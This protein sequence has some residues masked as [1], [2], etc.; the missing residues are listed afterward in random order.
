M[1]A[2]TTIEQTLK[3]FDAIALQDMADVSL[4]N[5]T[6]TKFVTTPHA[7]EKFLRLAET[8]CLALE[9]NDRRISNYYTLYFDTPHFEMFRCHVRGKANRQKLRIRSY[10][11]EQV[12]FL[13]VKTKD[14][15]RRTS[16]R[17]IRLDRP[18]NSGGQLPPD[19]DRQSAFVRE[20]LRCDSTLEPCIENRFRR[21]TLVDK[22]HT[23]RL[24]ID[25]N[26]R[27]HNLLT[28]CEASLDNI[29]IIELKRD[30]RTPSTVLPL[31]KSLK[32]KP[33]GFSKY[34]IGAALTCPS[35]PHNLLKARLRDIEKISKSN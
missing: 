24:T 26:I 16:K 29:V 22:A 17:R 7:L 2:N 13:E 30:G 19:S 18:V 27:F 15:R 12:S 14:N 20:N 35:L 23:E 34:C 4:M 11:D 5:R 25:F 8:G 31:L 21:I 28:Q 10:T 33:L 3:K 32:I 6:D 1:S 9:I